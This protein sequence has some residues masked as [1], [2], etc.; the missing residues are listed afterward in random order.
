MIPSVA[1]QAVVNP[2]SGRSAGRAVLEALIRQLRDSGRQ[3]SVETTTGPGDA[4]RV[5]ERCC[6]EGVGCLVVAGGDGTISE[7]VNGMCGEGVPVLVVPT[8]TENVLAKY[9]GLKLDPDRLRQVLDDG[10][11]VRLD[12][13]ICNGRRFLLMAG[14]GFDAEAVRL[15]SERRRGH[16]SYLSY[17]NPLWQ[18]FWHYRHPHLTIEADGETI[19]QGPGLAFVGSVPRYALG[20]HILRR[21]IPDDGLLDVCSLTCDRRLTLMRHT[22]KALL[23]QHDSSADVVYQQARRVRIVSDQ[24]VPVQIDGDVAGYLPAELEIASQPARFLVPEA[25]KTPKPAAG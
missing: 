20:L 13:P 18:A 17:L 19:F 24:R 10:H 23:G 11:E 16:L 15:V 7:V 2:I 14:V 4:R 21:A 6:R 5:A 12:V 22:L 8:G 3:V 25:W 9:M 1:I